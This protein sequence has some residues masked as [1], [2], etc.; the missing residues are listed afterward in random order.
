MSDA[1]LLV[2]MHLDAMVLNSELSAATP[3]ARTRPRYDNLPRM[4]PVWTPFGATSGDQPDPGIYLHWTLPRP[5]RHGTAT[6][7]GAAPEF[8]FVPNRW[9]VVRTGADGA[10]K[11]WVL[12]SDHV[13]GP[14]DDGGSPFV[15]PE[16]PAANGLPQ[17]VR[18]GRS[19]RLDAVAQLDQGGSAF[20]RA[21]GPGN[22]T[23]SVYGRTS[24][25]CSRSATT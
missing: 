14:D 25:T 9:V 21:V 24:R 13:H 15:D 7:D 23:F 19:Q 8:P 5:L 10:V 2:P 17:P 18:I 11:A 3:F 16:R 1:P 22:A 20:L 6:S 12:E 4:Q